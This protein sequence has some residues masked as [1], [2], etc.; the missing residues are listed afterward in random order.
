M[1]AEGRPAGSAVGV[2]AVGVRPPD[3]RGILA[4]LPDDGRF[5]LVAYSDEGLPP[6]PRADDDEA[7]AAGSDDGGQSE[8]ALA[9]YPDYNVLLQDPQVELVLVDGPIELRRDFAV[10]ALNA[11]R[12][13]VTAPPFCETAMD[14]ERVAK[15]AIRK[16]L[17]A[18]MDLKWRGDA[19]FRAIRAALAAENVSGVQGAFLFWA[20]SEPPSATAAPGLLERFGMAMLDQMRCVL[21][22]DV[23]SVNA[24]LLRPTPA[25]ADA[26]FLLY[27]PLRSG[28]WA[29][30]H[31]ASRAVGALPGW[32]LYTAQATFAVGHGRAVVSTGGE[33]RT[34]LSP[35]APVAF[36]DNVHAA[37]REGAELACHPA[38]IVHAMKL[39]EAASESAELREP[40]TV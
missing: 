34:Y 18:T 36:W 11:G 28:G 22:E 9:C 25:A 2:A 17:V 15:T 30:C 12:H 1:S 13:V 6:L 40:V 8:P 5:R 3:G 38:D 39:A 27:M 21:R 20:V 33:E 26:G 31:A 10:R 35:E 24:H 32:V 37:I 19:D 14:G 29:V 4:E 7:D 23:K 16:G